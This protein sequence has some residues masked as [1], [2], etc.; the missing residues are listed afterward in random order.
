MDEEKNVDETTQNEPETTTDEEE[1]VEEEETSKN[2]E[3]DLEELRKKAELAD[4][5]KVRAEKAEKKLKESEK[6]A[7]KPS[8]DDSLSTKDV[9]ALAKSTIHDDDVEEVI[10]Y[11]KFK[12]ISV[13][14]ALKSDY[15]KTYSSNREE[16]R[17]TAAATQTKGGQR[18]QAKVS[19][20]RIL[21]D[22]KSGKE[23]DP[24]KLAEARIRQ[25]KGK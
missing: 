21:S 5:Y 22:A 12:G 17:K 11:A 16:E 18:G 10:N 9:L 24:E 14:E 13:A 20:D 23:V 19:D 6:P 25:K 4:N 7:E 2:D 3:P 15:V 8:Q 1:T